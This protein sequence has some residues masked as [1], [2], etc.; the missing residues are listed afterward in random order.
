MRDEEEGASL[1]QA[2]DSRA[3]ELGALGIEI[4]RRLVED[5]EGRVAQE[6]ARERDPLQLAGGKWAAAVSDDGLVPVGQLVDECVG[7]GERRRGPDIAV[8]RAVASEPDV[9]GHGAAEQGRPLRHPGD[10]RPPGGRVAGREI[11][12]P[13]GRAA[14]RRLHQ[15][16]EQRGDRALAAPARADERHRL[17]GRELEIDRVEHELRPRRIHERDSLEPH[18]RVSR[19][20]RHLPGTDGGRRRLLEQLEEALRDREPVGARV[21]LGREVPQRQVELRRKHED[22]EAR[23]EAETP[24]DEA[25]ADG[26]RDERDPER[27][28][29]LQHGPREKR[30][31]ERAH[32]RAAVLVADPCNPLR[33]RLGPVEGTERRQPADDVREVAREASERAP[34]RMRSPL[35]VAADEPHEDRYEGEREEHHPGRDEVD[36]RDEDEHGDRHDHREHEL[37]QVAGERRLERV[38]AGD[39]DRRDLGAPRAVERRRPVA[40]PPLDEVE[41]QLREHGRRCAPPGNLEAPRRGGPSR[42]GGGKE[43][44]RQPE[45][46]E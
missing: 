19:A 4:R 7:S 1:P 34:A 6:R 15:P 23:L 3:D 9:V 29:E 8:R 27:R 24:F 30:D 12:G 35:G 40:E 5:D 36:R 43:H 16:E 22:G 33:L 17:A 38:D 41:S 21:E 45:A 42:C 32:R 20:R 25:N 11:D 31:A 44:E 18:R 2:L 28:R 46:S 13:H 26:H 39:G 10:L 37:W 14:A